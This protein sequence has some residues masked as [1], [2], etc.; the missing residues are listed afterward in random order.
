M[1]KLI[2]F[3]FIMFSV[4]VPAFAEENDA[5]S[6]DEV[7][8]IPLLQYDY[9]NLESQ[10]IHSPGMGMVLQSEDLMFVGLY[11][12]HTFGNT[13]S[14]NYPQTYHSI[15]GL[16]DGKSGP[17]QYLGIVKSESNKPVTGG[18]RT[19]VGAALYGYEYIKNDH[20]SLVFGGGLAAGDFGPSQIIPVPL[21]RL[22]Y[23]TNWIKLKFEFLTGPN[24]EFVV[25]PKSH[26]RW[27]TNARLDQFRD[28]RDLIF[29]TSLAYR[30]YSADSEMGDFAGVSVG[31]KN[32]N[33]GEFNVGGK[34]D[35]FYELHYYSVFAALDISVLKITAGY[36]FGGRELYKQKHKKN[37]GDG[38][39]L[40]AQA[41][42][43]F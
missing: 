25:G 41:M 10:S 11:T 43:Q 32:D 39:F 14:R 6:N 5:K 26:F 27:I 20:L 22:N 7:K 8:I 40:S 42:Y 12:K 35:E 36:A 38:Y 37:V 16:L 31:F 19:W 4:T 34:K 29:E 17:H 3:L 15:D 30:F 21:V 33:Y 23:E 1:K 24:F 9:L 28:S 2:I 13:L 18:I